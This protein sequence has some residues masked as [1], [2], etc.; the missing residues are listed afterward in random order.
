MPL[1]PP[2]T[3]GITILYTLSPFITAEA[4][5]SDVEPGLAYH[6]SKEAEVTED[7]SQ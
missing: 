3:G 7:P 6:A 4:G 5:A 1:T 2:S